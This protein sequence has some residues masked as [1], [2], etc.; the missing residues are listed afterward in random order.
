MAKNYMKEVAQLLGV[1]L[2][3]EFNINEMNKINLYKIN[4][5]GLFN[6]KTHEYCNAELLLLLKGKY[7]IKKHILDDIEKRYLES[8]LRPF[9]NNISNIKKI[10]T[11]CIK[12]SDSEYIRALL[13][14][15]ETFCFPYFKTNTMYKRMKAN[16]IYTL[17]ELGLFEED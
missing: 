8:V 4:E 11:C 3:E 14:H 17:E 9:K 15:G 7:E 2:H 16:K 10:D 6:I 13:K 1:K 5:D 12:Y